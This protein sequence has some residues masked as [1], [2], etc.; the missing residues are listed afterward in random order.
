MAEASPEASLTWD[1]TLPD[2]VDTERILLHARHLQRIQHMGAFASTHITQYQGET[3][4]YETAISSVQGDG[5]VLG[6]ASGVQQRADKV[7]SRL[8]DLDE[9]L[10]SDRSLVYARVQYRFNKPELASIVADRRARRNESAEAA[11]AAEINTMFDAATSKV[12]RVHLVER[13]SYT[14][15]ARYLAV[16]GLLRAQ[17]LLHVAR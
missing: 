17:Y 4:T 1:L 2:G 14:G 8:I 16:S 9:H 10:D 13:P 11:W 15:I 3:T 12:A 7:R 6:R 5:T